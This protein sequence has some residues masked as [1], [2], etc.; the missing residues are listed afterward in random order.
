MRRWQGLKALGCTLVAAGTMLALAGHAAAA[1]NVV[2]SQ[3]YGGGGNTGATYQNDYVEL[4][5]RSASPI[6]ITGWSVQYASATGTGNFA[7]NPVTTLSG[8]LAA[9]QYYLVKESGGTI[10]SPLPLADASGTVNMAAGGGKVILANTTT[11]LACNGGSTPCSGAQLAQ[12]V[13]LVG[14]DGANFFE[15]SAAAPT[16]SNTTAGFRAGA[17]CVDTDNNGA[18]FTAA[19]PLAR[20]TVS[21]FHVCPADNAP[22]VTSTSPAN[23]AAG[24][25]PGANVSITFSEPVNVADSWYSISCGTSGSHTAT[26]SGGPTTFTLDPDSDFV[27]GETCTVT[28]VAADVT[29]QDTIDPP[30]TMAADYVFSF[31]TQVPPTPIHTIQGATHISPYAGQSVRTTGIVTAKSSNGFWMQDPSP[32]A[33][34]ATSEGIFVFTSS[35]PAVA[36]GDS[37][38]VSARVQEFR[39]GGAS[40]GNLTTTELASPTVSVLSTGN[41]LPAP[42]VMGTG[43]RIPPDTVIENDAVGGSVENAGSVFDPAQDGL[44]FYESLEGMRVQLNDAVAVGPTATAFG[45]TPVIGDNGANASVRTYRGGILLRPNDGNPERVTLDDQLTSLPNVNVG[46]HYS[47]PVVGVMDYNFGN[48]FVEVTSPGLTAIHDGV[49]REVTAPVAPGELAVATFNFENLAPDNPQ[50]KFD[51]LASLIVNNLRSP[52][53]IA[54]EEVQDNTGATDNGV[55]DASQTLSKLVDAIVAAGGPRYAWREIDPVDDTDGGQPGGNIRQVFLFR[56]DRGLSFVDRPGG[57][58]TTPDAVTGSGASTQLLYSPGRIA[59]GDS[60]WSASRKPLAGEFDYRGHKLFVIANHFN[61]KGG[62]DPLRGRFQPPNEVTATQRHQQ[63]TLVAGFVSQLTSADPGANVVV[64]GDL[65]DYEF[66]PTVQILEG[67]G[68]NDLMDTLPLN[69]RYSYDF[70]GNSQVLDHIML[71]GPLFARSLVFDPV[72]VN[73]EFFDQASDHDPSVVRVQLNDPPSVAAGGPYSVDEGSS[74]SLT[75]SGSDP[76]GGPLTYAWDLDGNGTFETPGQTVSFSPDDGP[77]TPT[78]SVQATDDVGHTS[79]AQVT[80][81]VANVPPT[82][83]AL[84]PSSANGLTGEGVTFTGTATDPST[85]DTNA[86]FD[87]AFDAGSG[88]GA[89]GANGFVASFSSCGTYT[90]DAKA[91]DKD[92]GVSTALTSPPVHVYDGSVLPPLQSGSYNVVQRGRTVP[93]KITV[94][95]GGFLGGLHP[96]ISLRAGDY[97]PSVDPGDPSYVIPDSSS[98]AD[99][100]GVMRESDGQYV[101]NLAVPSSAASGQLYTVVVRPFGGSSPT[102]YA[103]L[104]IK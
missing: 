64:L 56:S 99:T 34:E 103:V 58:S 3:V 93:V 66:S 21:A 96:A 83:T 90:V 27:E 24:V 46:D 13:D 52:D 26:V 76:E 82:V 63:A 5:N 88:F 35:A 71:S 12:I 70:E 14:Y 44:D 31:T 81:T 104:K 15:G 4:F 91:R 9:G 54:G 67:A 87:W 89:F 94:G 69:Q 10:G 60:A 39:P 36:V 18:D 20:N 95:C 55:V 57:D 37:V 97:D 43:G 38:S 68:L 6:S 16:L 73:A 50:S 47:G 98:A 75:A 102:L 48:P 78:V 72:H 61:S 29:D 17:G 33:D 74:T 7:A 49:Q 85:A 65:N 1:G 41:S 30:D 45:E 59:P 77:A 23:G 53:L 62:D 80:V 28:V 25:V 42:V 22:S 100:S 8:V 11:G 86:G 32:D 92:G 40:N 2:I 51:G 19:S 79:T 84:M 101:Y